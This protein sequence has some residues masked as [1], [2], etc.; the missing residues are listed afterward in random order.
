MEVAGR[1]EVAGILVFAVDR[2]T[3]RP[4][5]LETLIELADEHGVAIDGPRSGRLDLT[6]A[7]GRQQAR[8]MAL[9]AAAESDNTSERIK[10][11]LAAQ[12]ARRQANGRR[13]PLWV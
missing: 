4:R 13:S 7:T 1:G 6:T 12:D 10:T 3:R 8:W 2:F 9:Q 5:D 11:T